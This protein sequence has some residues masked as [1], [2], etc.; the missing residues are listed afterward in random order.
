MHSKINDKRI[1]NQ[2][3]EHVKE[4]MQLN[5]VGFIPGIQGR[6]NIK[7]SKWDAQCQLSLETRECL[8]RVRKDFWWSP[9]WLHGKKSWKTVNRLKVTQYNEGCIWQ[10]IA[11]I[12]YRKGKGWAISSKILNET[13]MATLSMLIQYG[14]QNL[15]YI[16]KTRERYERDKNLEKQLQYFNS[17]MGQLCT[18][19]FYQENF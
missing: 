8:N 17:Q 11:N 7:S 13:G 15:S 5:Q 2:S 19:R 12:I 9:A 6:F 10:P 4:S 1:A 18:L 14:T 3:R 16:N